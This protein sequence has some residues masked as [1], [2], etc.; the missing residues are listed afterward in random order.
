[1]RFLAPQYRAPSTDANCHIASLVHVEM[2]SHS[3][4]LVTAAEDA[5]RA[6]D[7]ADRNAFQEGV[8]LVI[9]HLS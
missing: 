3:G 7:A 8:D 6:I 9:E 4:Q 2:V 1:M 5:L